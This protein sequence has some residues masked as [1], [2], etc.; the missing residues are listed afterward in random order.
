MQDILISFN[1]RYVVI[2]TQQA[3]LPLH[4][5]HSTANC[6]PVPT[7][8]DQAFPP[9]TKT[10]AAYKKAHFCIHSNHALLVTLCILAKKI[11]SI[12]PIEVGITLSLP[13]MFAQHF[14]PVG[15]NR[16]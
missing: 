7:I 15:I 2:L 1:A 8:C 16:L 9:Q 5:L 14:F 6:Q 10:F 4:T 12:L 3:E 11:C 13:N